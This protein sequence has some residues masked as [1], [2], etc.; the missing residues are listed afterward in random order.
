VPPSGTGE[1]EPRAAILPRSVK[2]LVAGERRRRNA[3]L[4]ARRRD[5]RLLF[6]ATL[7]SAFGTWLAFVALVV[8]V[9]D[10]TGSATWV[11]GLLIAEFAPLV[12]AGLL[13]GPLIDRLPRRAVLVCSDLI[14]AGLFCI[15][16]F[17]SD[18]LQIVLLAL[19]AGAA[20]SLFRPAVY[21]GVP[22]LLDGDDELPQANGLLQSAENVTLALGPLLGGLLV[23][24]TG[25]DVAYLVNAGSFGLSAVLILRIR[26]SLDAEAPS[27]EG[28]WRDLVAGL[29]LLRDS[30]ALRAVT[31]TWSVVMLGS[32]GVSVAEVVLAKEVFDA[33]DAGYGLMLSAM[34]IGLVA[35]GFA[36]GGRLAQ[37]G[38]RRLYAGAIA[39][40]ALGIGAVAVSPNVWLASVLLVVAGIGNGAA[41]VCN[42]VLIQR[43]VADRLRGRAFTLAMS[44]SYA[45]LGIGMIGA[46]P[47]TAAVG[48]RGVWAIAAGILALG[49]PAA[50]ALARAAE[51]A[52][53][54]AAASRP[55]G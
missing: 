48:A 38:S 37:H 4:L 28:H 12:V 18:A 23:A 9:F 51:P 11:S 26:R 34:G 22:S 55:A 25:P 16:P 15:L 40:M 30:P 27:S 36:A 10:R 54:E 50:L 21:A 49:V 45:A 44:A 43:N 13:L 7:A 41:L 6:L 2:H 53:P 8:D 1:T 29:A 46:G 42:A 32:A 35:G 47:L 33:G 39:L 17:A 3:G 20:T 19:A 14:R 31:I 52:A 5:F 24:W